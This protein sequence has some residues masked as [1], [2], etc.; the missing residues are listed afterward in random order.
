MS[1]GEKKKKYLWL[2]LLQI[3]NN[4][5]F[6]NKNERIN[7]IDIYELSAD[8]VR[9][10]I[11]IVYLHG[12]I[13]KQRKNNTVNNLTTIKLFEWISAREKKKNKKHKII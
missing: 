13:N 12:K 9:T 6:W 1:Q 4:I 11:L 7:K 2:Y 3:K 8:A 10:I 5:K